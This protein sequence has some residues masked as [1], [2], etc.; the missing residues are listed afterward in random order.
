MT[1]QK[2]KQENFISAAST[3]IR[4][5]LVVRNLV[6]AVEAYCW[7]NNSFYDLFD[8]ILVLVWPPVR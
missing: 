3:V 6:I 5:A 4:C 2:K 1:P 8:D 7:E